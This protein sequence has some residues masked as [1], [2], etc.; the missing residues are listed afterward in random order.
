MSIW[1]SMLIPEFFLSLWILFVISRL[2]PLHFS[3][4]VMLMSS[5]MAA[6]PFDSQTK[7]LSSLICLVK[8]F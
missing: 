2:R 4:G 1:S 3:S 7:F 8:D 6:E 5:M